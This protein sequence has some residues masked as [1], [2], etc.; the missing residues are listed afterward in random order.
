MSTHDIPAAYA[1]LRD[2]LVALLSGVDDTAATTI[3]PSCPA[4]TVRDLMAHVV[5]VPEDVL[6]GR[7]EGV[8]SDAWTQAQV[9]RHAEDSLTDLVAALVEVGAQMDPMLPHFPDAPR[10]QFLMDAVTHEHDIRDALGT[11]GGE[12]AD[13]VEIGLDWLLTHVSF[14]A[15]VV[16][17]ARS[18]VCSSY[19]AMRSLSGR[20]TA[21]QMTALG[22][23][24]DVIAQTL[25]ST[26][27]PAPTA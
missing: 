24:G 17:A 4:W 16:D 14:P 3:V 19:E 8:G 13:A 21:Q 18:G 26:P 25:L 7:L 10:G 2:R 27:F 12:D 20:R 6:A 5:G 9:D 15:E 11:P 23:P 22:L 1:A